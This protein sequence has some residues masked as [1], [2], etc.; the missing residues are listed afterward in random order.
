MSDSIRETC[1]DHIAGAETASISTDELPVKHRLEK[2]AKKHPDKVKLV[3]D[4]PDGSVFYH[5]PWKWLKIS[6]PRQ[7]SMSEAERMEFAKRMRN[8]KTNG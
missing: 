4:N 8:S 3:A 2:L 7:V 1:F 5:I 6:P